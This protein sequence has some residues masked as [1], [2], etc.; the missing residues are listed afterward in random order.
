MDYISIEIIYKQ[1]LGQPNKMQM[2]NSGRKFVAAITI[3]ADG[4]L[5]GKHQGLESTN[6]YNVK[7]CLRLH[8]WQTV[9]LMQ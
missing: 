6:S 1:V 7:N 2:D 5:P 3:T 9:S 8:R 4:V